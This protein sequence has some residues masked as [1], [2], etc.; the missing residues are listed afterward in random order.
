MG[1]EL[2]VA[3]LLR[4]NGLAMATRRARPRTTGARLPAKECCQ[5]A[6]ARCYKAAQT[7][8]VMG[9]VGMRM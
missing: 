7:P 3:A 5:K 2:L 6:V 1:I 8:A 9:R 4:E